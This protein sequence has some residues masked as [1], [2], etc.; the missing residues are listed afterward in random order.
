MSA[1]DDIGEYD[2]LKLLPAAIALLGGAKPH[3]SGAAVTVERI[4]GRF[5][6]YT[7]NWTRLMNPR[8]ASS[9]ITLARIARSMIERDAPVELWAPAT[10]G[11]GP[12]ST[13]SP[14]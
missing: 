6:R 5:D 3:D 8:Q 10:S 9:D 12:G 1:D 14:L 4:D 11:P 7:I 2:G 13:S